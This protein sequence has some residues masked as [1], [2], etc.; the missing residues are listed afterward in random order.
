[1][2]APRGG[3]HHV[4]GCKGHSRRP[5][6]A[7][8]AGEEKTVAQVVAAVVAV[9]RRR[10]RSCRGGGGGGGGGDGGGGI[11]LRCSSGATPQLPGL[12]RT[13]YALSTLQPS[14]PVAPHPICP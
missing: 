8:A 6:S 9:T 7:V 3:G 1:M 4:P 10:W 5:V 14:R 2:E 11:R 13:P 12:Y